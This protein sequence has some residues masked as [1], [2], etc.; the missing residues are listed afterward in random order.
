LPEP[1]TSAGVDLVLG[2][3]LL[4]RRRGRHVRPALGGRGGRFSLGSRRF[5]FR[6]GLGL[7]LGRGRSTLAFGDLCQQ[8]VD[9]D[10]LAVLGENFAQGSGD[11]RGNLDRDLVGFQ[12]H[13]R[14]VHLHGVAHLL[15]PGADGGFADG[16]TKGR[17]ADFSSP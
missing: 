12:F 1:D 15:E 5:A 10:R 2:H 9:L 13:Q 8:R 11:R 7:R 17:D 4:G 3:Q 16:F 6:L 14:L